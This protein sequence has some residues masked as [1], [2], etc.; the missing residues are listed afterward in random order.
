VHFLKPNTTAHIQ[1]FDQGIIR[2]FKSKYRRN[3]IK[4]CIKKIDESGELIMPD[5]KEPIFFIKDAWIN[6]SKE[7]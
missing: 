1:P 5:M 2:T 7:M 3:Q 4:S 6:V